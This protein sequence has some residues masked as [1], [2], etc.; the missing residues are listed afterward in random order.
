[1]PATPGERGLPAATERYRRLLATAE[2]DWS[3]HGR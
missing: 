1:L 2:L 3:D